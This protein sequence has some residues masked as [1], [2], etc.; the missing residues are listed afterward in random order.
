VGHLV[1]HHRHQK[2]GKDGNEKGK[3]HRPG[4]VRLFVPVVEGAMW[5]TAPQAA[6]SGPVVAIDDE[7]VL[8]EIRVRIYDQVHDY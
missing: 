1:D 5:L 6:S 7:P 2:D 4:K 8:L 3:V